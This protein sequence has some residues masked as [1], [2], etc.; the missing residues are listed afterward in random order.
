MEIEKL[1]IELDADIRIK[2]QRSCRFCCPTSFSIIIK[3]KNMETIRET[4]YK[5]AIKKFKKRGKNAI[6]TKRS[7]ES[8]L[9]SHV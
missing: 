1:I 4:S 2:S 9:N 3:A 7:T 6:I 8:Y 5:K